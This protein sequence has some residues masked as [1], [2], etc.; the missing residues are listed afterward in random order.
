MLTC[1]C[2]DA[3]TTSAQF[4]RERKRAIRTRGRAG[5]PS[6]CASGLK[7]EWMGATPSSQVAQLLHAKVDALRAAPHPPSAA[8][9]T[10]KYNLLHCLLSSCGDA[11]GDDP[12]RRL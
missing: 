5:A 6:R 12:G 8:S 7:R 11:D 3:A 1:K 9:A 10:L 2:E 4:E